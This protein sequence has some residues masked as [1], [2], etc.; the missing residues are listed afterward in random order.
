MTLGRKV[1]ISL[2]WMCMS[3]ALLSQAGIYSEMDIEYQT[4]FMEAE[5]AKQLGKIEDQKDALN[6]IIRR[7]P[8]EAQAYLELSKIY[9]AEDNKDLAVKNA[10]K[11]VTLNGSN[12]WYLLNLAEIYEQTENFEKASEAYEQLLIV[13]PKN[14]VIYHR[15]AVNYLSDNDKDNAI[16]VLTMLQ[17][18]EGIDEETSRRLF[19]IY[20]KTGDTE[21]ALSVLRQLTDKYPEN[22]RFLNNLAGY[23]HDLG[24]KAEAREIFTRVL[25][26][27]PN[28]AQASMALVREPTPQSQ[29]GDYLSSL[30]PVMT[31]M[32]IPLDNKIMELMPFIAKMDKNDD[33]TPALL[34]ISEKLV[35]LYPEEAKVYAIQGDVN[36]YAGN[37]KIAEAAYEK[38]VDL[39]DR[40]YT[41]W[42]QW[43]LNLWELELYEKLRET[44]LNALDLFPN[45][46]NAYI[47]HALSLHTLDKK[48]QASLFIEE[49][50]MIGGR[51]AFYAPLIQLADLWIRADE[52]SSSEIKSKLQSIKPDTNTSHLTFELMGDLYSLI[53]NKE[54]SKLLWEEAIL[55]GASEKRLYKKIKA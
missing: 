50:N 5:L 36:F 6:E 51:N 35:E 11:A 25:E 1:F 19:D 4:L 20:N 10:K 23:L 29:A 53:G 42:D 48:S 54:K 31:N 39:N 13:M 34:N 15:L 52:I 40:K 55:R 27:D 30:M 46:V 41:L 8:N 26:L 44:S 43:M 22:V 17:E 28:N 21:N 37:Y 47:L 32:N 2:F 49:A 33:S 18:K 7:N 9:F 16:R 24:K 3:S 38:S 14:P 12:E 45:Q